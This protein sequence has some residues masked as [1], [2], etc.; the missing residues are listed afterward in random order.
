MKKS[1]S[2]HPAQFRSDV[3]PCELEQI[4]KRRKCLDLP[5]VPSE[6]T[7]STGLGLIGLALSGGGIR[8]ATFSLGV[9]QAL[10]KHGVL[11]KVDYLSTVSGGGFIG[12]CL[13]S[14]LNAKDTGSEQDRFPLH[15]Q[16]G[17]E[18]PLGVG[19]LRNS[20]H[21]LSPGGFLDK[22][23]I[24][25]LVLRGALSNLFLFLLII[26]MLVLVTEL[27]YEVGLHQH[28]PFSNLILGGL[29]AFIVLVI[30]FPVIARWFRGGATWTQRHYWDMTFTVILLLV[31]F[32]LFLIPVFIL[33]DQAIDTSWIDMKDSVTANL[34]RPFEG[35]DYIQWL[36]LVG[37]LSILMLAG[38]AS[39]QVSQIGGKIILIA[40]GLLGPAILGMIYLTLVVLQIDSPFITPDE[41]FSVDVEYVEDL[42]DEKI[43]PDL[44]RHFQENQI[45]LSR[46]AEVITL[47]K[48][49]RWMIRDY[50]YAFSLVLEQD[51]LSVYPD[52]QD[53][54]SRG[55]TPPLLILS[56][57][58][59]GYILDTVSTSA[60]VLRDNQYEI[61]GSRLYVIDYDKRDNAWFL[62]QI[63]APGSLVEILESTSYNLQIMDSPSKILI[64]EGALLSDDDRE[65]AIRFVEE[66]NL[67]D[68]VVIIDNSTPPFAK[69]E[70]FIQTFREALE[71]ALKDIRSTVR[72]AVFWFDGDVHP[73]VGFTPLTTSNKQTLIQTLYG[74]SDKSE[75]QLDFKGQLSN[76]PAALVRAMREITEKGRPRVKKSILLIS[77]GII[78][79]DGTGHHQQLEDWI[80]GEF[81][82][83][84]ARAGVSFYGIALSEKAIFPIFYTLAR[85]TGGAFRSKTFSVPWK[86]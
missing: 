81:A 76:I 71:P 69:P 11:K 14:V 35:R 39:R 3:F 51:E 54:L 46:N 43:S 66:G 20:A 48:D 64:N 56:M 21:Y 55:K 2:T 80:K 63:V 34:L 28:V 85:K 70:E 37:V 49:V 77:D 36:F 18:E 73:V 72:M 60:A 6:N 33:V 38:R 84:I 23:K 75:P 22:A 32:T 26:L 67:H 1:H 15:Y 7:P 65:L 79:I 82:D 74:G 40:L 41:L 53:A 29:S 8:S 9:I 16:V 27:V 61:S 68:V 42:S 78:D 50:E 58:K 24:P 57:E 13:S 83:D 45:R 25:A 31:L 5:D 12:S 59:K 44:R 52:F 19:Q 4:R 47:Q 30:G 10:A 86:N 62:E 17:T